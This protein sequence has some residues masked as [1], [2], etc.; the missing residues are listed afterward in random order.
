MPRLSLRPP[1]RINRLLT[2]YMINNKNT[3]LGLTGA[4]I[5]YLLGYAHDYGD[6]F[7]ESEPPEKSNRGGHLAVR[8]QKSLKFYCM[9]GTGKP[10]RN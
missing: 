10:I 4:L 1:L 6:A 5:F 3:F 7:K 9:Q 8:I 2:K